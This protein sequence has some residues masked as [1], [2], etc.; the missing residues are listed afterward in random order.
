MA[1][2]SE[3]YEFQRLHGMGEALHETVRR[4]SGTRTRIYAPVGAHKDLLAYLV[5]RLLENGANGSFVYQIADEDIPAST[6][7]ED[8]ITKILSLDPAPEWSG[9]SPYQGEVGRGFGAQI[10]NPAIPSPAAIFAPRQNSA[11]LDLT[12]PVAFP[13]MESA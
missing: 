7:A 3:G 12:D 6:V 5:R 8:P 9:S 2:R 4:E 1:G 10:P 11:G 13:A